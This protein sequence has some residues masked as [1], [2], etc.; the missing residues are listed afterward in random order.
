MTSFIC[1]ISS[2]MCSGG[3][4]ATAFEIAAGASSGF[5]E[6][7]YGVSTG[8]ATGPPGPIVPDRFAVACRSY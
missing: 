7:P 1:F 6:V 3:N 2:Y 5:T 4:D 8:G